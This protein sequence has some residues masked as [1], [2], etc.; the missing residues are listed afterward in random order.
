MGSLL[1]PALLLIAL[2]VVGFIAWELYF[3]RSGQKAIVE[4]HRAEGND[5]PPKVF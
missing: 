2:L 5:E 4:Q 1:V 3:T